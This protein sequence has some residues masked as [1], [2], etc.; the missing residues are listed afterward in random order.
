M[1]YRLAVEIARYCVANDL[2]FGFDYLQLLVIL[3]SDSRIAE[4]RPASERFVSVDSAV[5]DSDS[6]SFE[7]RLVS[8]AGHANGRQ[9]FGADVIFA[10][11][12]IKNR[13]D[14]AGD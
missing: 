6:L 13:L 8:R 14:T 2:G 7:F 12:W 3:R 4:Y 1:R 5:R 9:H 10:E 11:S